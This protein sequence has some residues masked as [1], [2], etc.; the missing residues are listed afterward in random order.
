MAFTCASPLGFGVLVLTLC[1]LSRIILFFF[2]VF[3]VTSY[4]ANST[5]R[6]TEFRNF[7]FGPL[8]RSLFFSRLN[9][10]GPFGH[11]EC[12]FFLAR[13][14]TIRFP[15]F[16]LSGRLTYLRF[17]FI[18]PSSCVYSPFFLIPRLPLDRFCRFF[19]LRPAFAVVITRTPEPVSLSGFFSSPVLRAGQQSCRPNSRR[20]DSAAARSPSFLVSSS[21]I[22][23]TSPPPAVFTFD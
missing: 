16:F 1:G 10:C 6:F 13:K 12:L 19:S 20:P 5:V 9:S 14:H 4:S 18:F 7:S 21:P 15:A 22:R 11:L 23:Q 2:Q 17:T 3:F 8:R